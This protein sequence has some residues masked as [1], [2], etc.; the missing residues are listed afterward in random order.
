M[1]LERVDLNGLAVVTGYGNGGFKVAGERYEGSLLLSGDVLHFWPVADF[2]E[3]TLE[4]LA[5]M[6]EEAGDLDLIL[7]GTGQSVQ[8]LPE[9]VE[10]ALRAKGVAVEC[11]DTGAACRTYS[12]LATEGRRVAGALI[13]V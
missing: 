6:I 1:Q 2:S 5:P 8:R 11:M 13:A 12:F 4:S 3:V 9:G 10:Q 7:F